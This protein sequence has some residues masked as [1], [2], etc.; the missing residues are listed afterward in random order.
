MEKSPQ[1]ITL[2]LIPYL[3]V[4]GALYHIAYWDTFHL[5]GLSFI[6]ISDIIKS[7][8]APIAYSLF[9]LLLGAITTR[10]IWRFDKV[11]PSG[12][13]KNTTVGK[14][15]N[16]SV[17]LSLILTLWLILVVWLYLEANSQT[18]IIWGIIV[19]IPPFLYIST[20]TQF[21]SGYFK[22]ESSRG[23]IIQLL[24]YFVVL[25]FATGKYESAIIKENL[26]FKYTVHTLKYEGNFQRAD[27]IKLLGK[28]EDHF[29]FSN[30]TNDSIIL[31][32]ADKIDTLILS[33]CR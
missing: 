2:L 11:F 20:K 5:N 22:D 9:V 30:L 25:S 14:K 27:T 23:H 28:T 10:F 3:T 13:G 24:V 16:S 33:E 32:R 29:I 15:L 6:S 7:F 1:N 31:I 4:C 21:L 19:A 17:G 26:K 8:A 18:W 12:G